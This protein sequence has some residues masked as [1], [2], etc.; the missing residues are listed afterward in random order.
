M[1]ILKVYKF[2]QKPVK[3]DNYLNTIIYKYFLLLTCFTK[4][5]NKRKWF[6]M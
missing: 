3:K 2:W 1:L 5:F 6:I 4:Y